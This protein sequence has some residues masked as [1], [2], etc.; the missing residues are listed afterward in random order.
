MSRVV[1]DNGEIAVK[2][3]QQS[4]CSW[5]LPFSKREKDTKQINLKKFMSSGNMC[6]GEQ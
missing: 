4:L 5:N 3:K 1:S 2:N 6:Y